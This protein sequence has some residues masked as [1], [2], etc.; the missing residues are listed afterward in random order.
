MRI[1][2]WSI[3]IGLAVTAYMERDEH[4]PIYQLFTA[5]VM[6]VCAEVSSVRQEVRRGR[7]P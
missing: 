4:D 6:I 7:K 2:W 5:L 1:M 3:A